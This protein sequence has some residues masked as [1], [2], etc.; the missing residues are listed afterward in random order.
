M[1]I[2]LAVISL[3]PLLLVLKTELVKLRKCAA[4]CWGCLKNPGR[5][6]QDVPSSPHNL[7][8]QLPQ[9]GTVVPLSDRRTDL[10]EAS[11]GAVSPGKD[12]SFMYIAEAFSASE[13][14]E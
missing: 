3:F 9:A 6:D 12:A 10:S 4:H 2:L 7:G 11:S 14:T 1:A 5:R 8:V 13:E